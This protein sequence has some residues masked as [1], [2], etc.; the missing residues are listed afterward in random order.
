MGLI[1]VP[2]GVYGFMFNW[3]LGLFVLGVGVFTIFEGVT[4]WTFVGTLAR[5]W[6]RLEGGSLEMSRVMPEKPV[7]EKFD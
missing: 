7:P 2:V 5:T 6:I 1:I 4:G 3:L